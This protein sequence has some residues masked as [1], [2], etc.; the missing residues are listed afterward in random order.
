VS[1]RPPPSDL[2]EVART[3]L[4]KAELCSTPD[5]RRALVAIAGAYVD[6]ARSDLRD[7]EEATGYSSPVVDWMRAGIERQRTEIEQIAE[8]LRNLQIGR[9]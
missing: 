4:E 3:F 8:R 5:L 1:P 6:D 2:L 7:R 9:E